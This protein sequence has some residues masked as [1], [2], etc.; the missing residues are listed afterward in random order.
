[1]SRLLYFVA[2]EPSGDRLGAALMDALRARE[3]DIRFTGLGGQRMQQAGLT[4][5]FDILDLNV[6]GLVEVLPRL[7]VLLRRIAQTRAD[8]LAKRPDAL[9]TIDSPSFGLR[10]A[11]K[12]RA[13]APSIRTIHYVAPSV[14]AWRP[15]RAAHMARFVD[16][17]LALLPFEPP[18]MERAGMTCDFVGHP[19]AARQTPDAA[20]MEKM[21]GIWG[22][23][24]EDPLLL[25]APG[26]RRGEV[27]RLMPVF[28]QIVARLATRH[29]GLRPIIPMAETVLGEVQQ[30]AGDMA[31][32]PVLIHPSDGEE[33]KQIAF[34]AA[35]A[36]LIASGTIVLEMAAARTPM[37]SCY[38][39]N[40][41]TAAIV[42]RLIR[43]DTANLV[44]LVSDT[45]AVPEFLQ[46]GLSVDAVTHALDKLLLPGPA[47]QAQL[48]AFGMVMGALG[49]NGQ[50]PA[51]RA[52]QSVL[53]QL[54]QA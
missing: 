35:D 54:P 9:I 19:I 28:K 25:V 51:D 27:A 43:V 49:Q 11:E 47:R 5:L 8:V 42:R 32:D 13:A 48:D 14:W 33:L 45:Q 39:T 38:R 29:P 6:M 16:H 26:S 34:A 1:M 3:P 20:T 23:R 15:K 46:E 4:P 40:A 10:V 12:V 53:R 50:G 24:P 7:P 17:V 31:V 36:A 52:A 41:L 22:M 37:V 18:Y 30:A 44:N 2:G 21:R